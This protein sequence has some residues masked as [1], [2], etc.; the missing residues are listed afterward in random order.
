MIRD[1]AATAVGENGVNGR[2]RVYGAQEDIAPFG[3]DR[4]A[5]PYV[6]VEWNSRDWEHSQFHRSLIE[7]RLRASLPKRIK[8]NAQGL[9]TYWDTMTGADNYRGTRER[10][11]LL[12]MLAPMF[13][14]PLVVASAGSLAWW[15]PILVLA[16]AVG[17]G[18]SP[19]PGPPSGRPP[20]IDGLA[21]LQPLPMPEYD[22]STTRDAMESMIK[23]A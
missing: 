2:F 22:F 18:H 21:P 17:A 4:V 11:V 10:D 6:V 15:L 9:W 13:A 1:A 7:S 12:I 19:W 20:S 23:A 5:T 16:S 8:I 3:F 14:V